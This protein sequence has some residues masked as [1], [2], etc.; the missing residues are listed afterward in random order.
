MTECWSLPQIH[1]DH[2]D[3]PCPP[4]YY[5]DE[6][7]VLIAIPDCSPD[8][9][10]VVLSH[11]MAHWAV[12]RSLAANENPIWFEAMVMDSSIFH[13]ARQ[14]ME[15]MAYWS[16]DTPVPEYLLQLADQRRARRIIK[17][18][19]GSRSWRHIPLEDPITAEEKAICER[20]GASRGPIRLSIAEVPVAERVA[21]SAPDDAPADCSA[22]NTRRG[23]SA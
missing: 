16:G 13:R 3:P 19:D 5:P 18:R 17:H 11:E 23:R 6:N 8:Y 21:D 15:L 10:V 7:T 2:H 4:G 14:A 20:L 12:F 22:D 9:L 1:V